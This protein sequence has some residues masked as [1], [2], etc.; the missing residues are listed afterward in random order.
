MWTNRD[1][2]WAATSAPDPSDLASTRRDWLQRSACG[3]G[4]LALSGLATIDAR[5]GNRQPTHHRPTARRVIFLFLHGGGF[6]I[7]DLE[8]YNN[9]CTEISHALDLP[10]GTETVL[11]VEDEALLR[12]L[13]ASNLRS[14]GVVLEATDGSNDLQVAKTNMIGWWGIVLWVLGGT[15]LGFILGGPIG[16]LVVGVLGYFL[17]LRFFNGKWSHKNS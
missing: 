16:A 15:V 1:A 8:V 13:A 3:F 7:G 6:V 11:L 9:L 12:R 10:V 14:Q 2:L 17:P 4:Y 5:G